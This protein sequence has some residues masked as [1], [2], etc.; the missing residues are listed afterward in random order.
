M[1]H[2]LSFRKVTLTDLDDLQHISIKTFTDA[3]E[4]LNNPADFK[5]YVASAY[6]AD[7]LKQE[8][9]DPDCEFYF[10]VY[11][12]DIAGYLK[13][14]FGKAQAEF[15]DDNSMEIARVYVSA[16]HQN[17]QIG[18]AML[19]FAIDIAQQKK[20]KYAWLGAWEN[21]PNAIRFYQRHDFVPI[22]SHYFMVGNDRQT[23]ILM[24]K[25]L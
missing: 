25:M 23:D 17:K 24:K 2:H 21:N 1:S 19:D 5:A 10:A 6:N 22:G 9:S 12:N 8:I 15:Q 3:F 18:K 14:S 20:L 13:L 4:K 11:Q 7:Q 16:T